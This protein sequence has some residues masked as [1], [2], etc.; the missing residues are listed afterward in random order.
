M[1]IQSK[2]LSPETVIHLGAGLC[3][4]L[5][6]YQESGAEQIILVEADPENAAYLK[7]QYGDSDTV[8]IAEIAVAAQ[9]G[10]AVL[11]K[12]NTQQYNSLRRPAKLAELFPGLRI[13]DEIE[14]HTVTVTDFIGNYHL[15]KEDQNWL[16]IDLPGEEMEITALLCRSGIVH[17]FDQITLYCGKEGLYENNVSADQVLEILRENGFDIISVNE[18]DD[19]DRPFWKLTRN[20]LKLENYALLQHVSA[21]EKQVKE[22]EQQ[23]AEAEQT[24]ERKETLAKKHINEKRLLRNSSNKQTVQIEELTAQVQEL[25]RD[26]EQKETEIAELQQSLNSFHQDKLQYTEEI[27]KKNTVIKKLEE[28]VEQISAANNSQKQRA[29]EL[30]NKN[31]LNQKQ[32]EEIVKLKSEIHEKKEL[33]SYLEKKSTDNLETNKMLKELHSQIEMQNAKVGKEILTNSQKFFDNIKD[34][35]AW[36]L[37]REIKQ[38]TDQLK[39]FIGLNTFFESSELL[40]AF[41]SWTIAPDLAY[42]LVRQIYDNEYDLI[43]EFGSGFSTVAMAQAMAQ[44]FLGRPIKDVSNNELLS[45]SGG[46]EQIKNGINDGE[47]ISENEK[48]INFERKKVKDSHYGRKIISFEHKREFFE[49]TSKELTRAR[50]NSFVNLVYAPLREYQTSNDTRQ[51]FYGC[52]KVLKDISKDPDHKIRKI[53]SLVDGP[54]GNIGKNA[55]YPA[56][57]FLLEHFGACE[58]DLIVDDTNREDEKGIIELWMNE[59]ERRGFS[60]IRKDLNFIRGAIK[61]SIR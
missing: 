43:I 2:K 16:V 52:D 40:P 15:S 6:V 55:R 53:L 50:M 42:Y 26:K 56:L 41:D 17:Y 45:I 27:S 3:K 7:R 61:L 5:S 22:L 28:Q 8:E 30:E 18:E 32:Y 4:E 47:N 25:I 13:V 29:D 48:Q 39:S 33:I 11:R 60:L 44:K 20:T 59:I 38:S 10:T 46:T 21:L 1:N 14:V 54:P 31:E 51:L 57:F 23:K 49:L 19:F 36:N 12:Y 58:I 24:A 34:S 9:E 37:K 35:F